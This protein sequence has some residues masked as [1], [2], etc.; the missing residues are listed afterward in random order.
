MSILWER[1]PDL[2]NRLWER[3]PGLDKIDI[4]RCLP[5]KLLGVYMIIDGKKIA[6]Y[7]TCRARSPDLAFKSK[8]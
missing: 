7:P 1:S 4:G 3:P 6:R 5:Q 2:D 8:F